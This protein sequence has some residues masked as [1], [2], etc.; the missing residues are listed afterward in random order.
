VGHRGQG[1][2]VDPRPQSVAETSLHAQRASTCARQMEPAR[3]RWKTI[4]STRPPCTD[5]ENASLR[6]ARETG[7]Q[8]EKVIETGIDSARLS[9]GGPV[10]SEDGPSRSFLRQGRASWPGWSSGSVASALLTECRASQISKRTR[11]FLRFA[12]VP[13]RARLDYFFISTNINIC[14]HVYSYILTYVYIYRYYVYVYI[15]TY[16][17]IYIHMYLYIHICVY[18]YICLCINEHAY[19]HTYSYIFKCIYTLIYI[20]ETFGSLQA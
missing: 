5:R 8:A 20:W 9:R 12:E 15:Y 1:V 11:P 16:I 3:V 2:S 14:I 18:L 17:Y 4:L 19:I 6:P 13:R 7:I 10:S